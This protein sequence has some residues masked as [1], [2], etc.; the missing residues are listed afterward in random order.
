MNQPPGRSDRSDPSSRATSLDELRQLTGGRIDLPA[1]GGAPTRPATGTILRGVATVADAGPEHVTW[2]A[3]KQFA[4][5]LATSQAG[6]VIVPEGFGP[7]PMPAIAV[8]DVEAAV[9]ETL[10]FFAPDREQPAP[11]IHATAV[12]APDARIDASAAIGAWVRVGAGTSVGAG[13]AVH[14]GAHLAAGVTVGRHCSIGVNAYVGDHCRLG[15]RVVLKPGAV[16]GSDGFGFYFRN[17]RHNPIPQIGNVVLEDDVQVGANTCIDRAKVASTLIGRGTKIDNLVQVGHNCRL[18]PHCILIAQVGLS[19]NTRAGAGV[20]F[21]GQSAT[22][23]D[24]AICDGARIGARA[25]VTKDIEQPG[26]YLG[27]PAQPMMQEKRQAIA[28]HRLP[29]LLATIKDMARRI[30]DLE[31]AERR[32]AGGGAATE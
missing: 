20:L 1:P 11:G 29:E 28:S 26:D 12:I 9:A 27:F 19:G 14:A 8:K 2:A 5:A 32:R 6:A 13:T 30:A 3:S 21:T 7:T 17:G 15:D 25:V 24:V 4:A 18:G 22:V 16:I 23:H 31:N 10:A